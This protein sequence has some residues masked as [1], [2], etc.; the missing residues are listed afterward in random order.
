MLKRTTEDAAK[1]FKEHGCELL[2]E[3]VGCMELMDYKCSCGCY[4]IITWNNFTKGKR[5]GSCAKTGQSKKRSVDQVRAIFA[6]RGCEFLDDKFNGVHHLHN[7]K[8]KCGTEAMITFAAFHFQ[9]QTCKECGLKKMTGEG[10]PA[11]RQDREQ[12]KLEQKFRK[13]CYKALQ[14]SLKATGKDK[15]GRTSDMLGY[16]PKQLQEHV[17]KH[18]NW[19]NVKDGDWHLDHIWPIAAFLEHNIVDI[20]LIN[21]LENLRPVSQKENNQKHAKYNKKEFKKWLNLMKQ[22][23]V[24][25]SRE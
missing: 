7:Y 3:Y 4:S 23:V 19:D 9:N 17:Q 6:E 21:H 20:A 1:Y 25:A 14:S 18:R 8:C 15:I 2:D 10:N 5:C 11:W 24:I 22:S 12:L 16:T 13:K